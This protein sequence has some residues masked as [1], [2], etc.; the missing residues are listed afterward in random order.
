MGPRQIELHIFDYVAY[1][2]CSAFEDGLLCYMQ[3]RSQFSG[4]F[5]PHLHYTNRQFLI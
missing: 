1:T 4:R 5:I 3:T 2:N